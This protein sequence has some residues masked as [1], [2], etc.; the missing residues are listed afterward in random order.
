MLFGYSDSD[1]NVWLFGA[2]CFR[3]DAGVGV[4][5]GGDGWELKSVVIG[6]S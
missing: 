3:L 4:G 2:V 6:A 1:L 5:I